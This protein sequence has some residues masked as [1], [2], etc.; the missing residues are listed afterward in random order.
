[1]GARATIQ[2]FFEFRDGLDVGVDVVRNASLLESHGTRA[3]LQMSGRATASPATGS[4]R[5]WQVAT[6][7]KG[8]D[9]PRLG[10]KIG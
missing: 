7:K 5:L 4:S 3:D 6:R 1:M 9:S 8:V 2:P 10:R